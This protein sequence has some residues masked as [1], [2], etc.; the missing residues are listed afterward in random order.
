[1]DVR[2][3]WRIKGLQIRQEGVNGLADSYL[4]LTIAV[5]FI[6]LHQA[7]IVCKTILNFVISYVTFTSVIIN[8][9]ASASLYLPVLM[10][11][12]IQIYQTSCTYENRGVTISANRIYIEA[13]RMIRTLG[14][15]E[16]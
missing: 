1:M 2:K 11:A 14:A 5:S 7:V 13:T 15:L 12:A 4:P 9:R 8:I 16:I 6:S 10:M 3:A